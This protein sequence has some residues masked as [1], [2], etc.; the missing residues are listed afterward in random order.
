MVLSM[1]RFQEWNPTRG[2]EKRFDM[3]MGLKVENE[4]G[5]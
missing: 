3:E 2:R 1:E 5:L 4:S